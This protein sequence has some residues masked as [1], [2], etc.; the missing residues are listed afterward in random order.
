MSETKTTQDQSETGTRPPEVVAKDTA[1]RSQSEAPELLRSDAGDITATS[2]SM[3]RSG[4]EQ[5]TADRVSLQQSGAKSIQTKSAQLDRSGVLRLSSD[6]TVLHDS[7]AISVK[8]REAR[9]I[10]GRILVFSSET[11]RVEGE[12]KPLI[13]IGQACEG[14]KPVLDGQGALKLGAALGF[15]LLVFGRL[16][17]QV[18]G[19]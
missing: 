8:T 15:V 14:V 7:S 3:D 18:T 2:V 10:K 1:Y 9:V 4:A 13:H 16:L 17:R 6:N 12:L 11:T 5:I 19:R